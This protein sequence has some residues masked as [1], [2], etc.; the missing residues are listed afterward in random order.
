[1]IL[2]LETKYGSYP[3]YARDDAERDR[4]YLHLF[5]FMDGYNY[6]DG[7]LDGDQVDWYKKA[8]QGDAQAARWL[9]SYRSDYFYEH[10]RIEVVHPIVP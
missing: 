1:M 8:E 10:E 6:Y 4:A 9:L 3:V 7:I 2:I 5:N